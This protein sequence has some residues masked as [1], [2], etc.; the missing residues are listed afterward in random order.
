V[1]THLLEFSDVVVKR[2]RSY[3]RGEH[4]R[5]WLGLRLLDRHAPGLAPR[6]LAADLT[7]DPPAVTMSRLPGEP[8]GGRPLT[9]AELAAVADAMDRLHSAVPEGEAAGLEP[10]H[11]HPH[12]GL[13]SL[14][15]LLDARPGDPGEPTVAAAVAAA[16]RWLRSAEA[17][18]AADLDRVPAVLG[19]EDHNLPNFLRHGDRLALVDFEDCGRSDRAT[20][21]AALVEHHAARCTADAA[22]QPL[23]DAVA[24]QA[25]LRTARRYHA[26]MWVALMLPGRP[27]HDR[28]PPPARRGQAERLLGL[29]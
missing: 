11:G 4:R 12:R 8:L 22:W 1:T 21:W 19:R 28:N 15:A 16:R 14:Q 2:F 29:L 20:E 24:D 25:R 5:E 23:L 17:A 9:P 27:G 3:E 10:S 26:C 13:A 6:P 18:G 7:A